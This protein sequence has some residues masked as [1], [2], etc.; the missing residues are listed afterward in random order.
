MSYSS[1]FVSL[2]SKAEI[3]S[4]PRLHTDD[5]LGKIDYYQKKVP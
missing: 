1:I 4:E 5:Y 3:K 2:Y